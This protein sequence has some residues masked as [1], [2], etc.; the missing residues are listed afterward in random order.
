MRIKSEKDFISGLFFIALGVAFAWGATGYDVGTASEM[1][2]G[3]FPFALGVILTVLGVLVAFFSLTVET[4]GGDKFGAFAWKPLLCIIGA[5]VVF[6]ICLGGIK[7]IGLPSLGLIVAI[8][9]LV[10]TASLAAESYKL[11]EVLSLSAGLAFFCWLGFVK[12]LKLTI[13]V[14]PAFFG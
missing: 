4:E 14:L 8:F 6:G 9:A 12:F 7:P 13:P 5:N 10:L 3:Y 11:P 2:P 1:G